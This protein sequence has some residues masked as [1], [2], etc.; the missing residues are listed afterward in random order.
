MDNASKVLVR[1]RAKHFCEY[2]R[3]HQRD[4]PDTTFH[5]EHIIA[6]QHGGDD[7]TDN[8]ALACHLCNLKKGP[9][10]AGMDP[11]NGE[12]TRLFNP[13][14]DNWQ[15]HFKLERSGEIIGLTAIGRTTANLLG[16][17]TA[18]RVQMRR[19]ISHLENKTKH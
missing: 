14:L 1:Q 11:V 6:R 18:I 10:V 17:N 7:S 19:E 12:L 9:N 5:M 15:E 16:M 13:R 4:Y 3:V 8:L 2:C